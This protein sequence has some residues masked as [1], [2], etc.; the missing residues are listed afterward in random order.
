MQ[1]NHLAKWLNNEL[2]EEELL[3][4]KKS[5]TYASYQKIVD[6][7]NKIETPSFD[8]EKAFADLKNKQ[9]KKNVTVIKLN[10]FKRI[11]KIAAAVAIL[12]AGS[13]YFT[14]LNSTITTDLAERTDVYLPDSS[15]VI[16]NAESKISFNKKTWNENRNVVLEGEAFFKV[17]KGKHFTVATESGIITVLGTQF[18][19]E[20]RENFFEVT[21]YEGLVS[22][23]YNNK[24]TKL[25]AGTSFLVI[26][27]KIENIDSLI[28]I[29]PSW[30]HDE[31]TFTSIPL[32][33]VLKELQRQYDLTIDTENIDTEKLFSGSFSNTNMDL[34]LESI[35]TPTNMNYKIEGDKVIFYAKNTP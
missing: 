24:E 28:A 22:V 10:P 4:F 23:T 1:E 7:S 21:C 18:S 29:E 13:Y 2:T 9:S 11:L 19:V 30:M 16:L 12:F 17:A 3:E 6:T 31:S 34:A 32:S 20:N 14:T 26:N 33:Y 15:L 35:V 5:D 8:I 25:A 27:N